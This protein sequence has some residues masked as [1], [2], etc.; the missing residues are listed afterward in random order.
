[1]TTLARILAENNRSSSSSRPMD[2]EAVADFLSPPFPTK[3]WYLSQEVWAEISRDDDL[4]GA[5]M[6]RTLT[7]L[8]ERGLR[9]DDRLVE[10]FLLENRASQNTGEQA[11]SLRAAADVS[12]PFADKELLRIAL[13]APMRTK[14]Q[15]SLNRLLL[16]RHAPDLA[17]QP[18]AATLVRASAP[19]L[20]QEATRLM[21][22]MY[23]S[24]RWRSHFVSRGLLPFPRTTWWQLEFLRDGVVFN[25]LL[26]DLRSDIWDRK[27][28]RAR[29]ADNA[30]ERTKFDRRSPTALLSQH[31]L[32]IATVDRMLR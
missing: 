8:A 18:T 4:F 32:R 9:T 16:M 29:I 24:G 21:R 17:A 22:R 15:N 27:A 28:I 23:E 20:V 26:D 31:M 3:P 30:S 7:R 2:I 25:S 5:D 11:L 19:I 12:L 14:I 13:A 6:L 10:T 1:M